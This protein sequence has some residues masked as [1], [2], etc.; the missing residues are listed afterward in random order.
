MYNFAGWRVGRWLGFEPAGALRHAMA[1][2]KA[3]ADLGAVFYAF[4]RDD[5]KKAML[6]NRLR[7]RLPEVNVVVRKRRRVPDGGVRSE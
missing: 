2:C 4:A 6:V 7:G 1:A 5:P 3:S